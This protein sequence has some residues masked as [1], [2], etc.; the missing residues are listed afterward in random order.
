MGARHRWIHCRVLAALHLGAVAAAAQL[1]PVELAVEIRD[2]A[3]VPSAVM[4]ET[5][6]EVDSTFRAT[7]VQIRWAD[8]GDAPQTGR[9]PLRLFL[10]G[11]PSPTVPFDEEPRVTTLGLAPESGNWAQVFY[12]RV[13]G[14]V[15]RRQ[16]SIGVVL[17]HVIAH[18]LGHLL[19]PPD[20]HAPVGVMRRSVDLTH[21]AFRRFT[22]DQARLI[23]TALSSG[24]RYAWACN[25]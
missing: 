5:K 1:A 15:A 12:G 14:A 21:P 16:V 2:L 7:G 24:R 3:R 11:S 10:V 19:L 22:D 25:Q 8:L 23:R 6:A 9:A 18:E 20:S 13:A 4:R 17:A